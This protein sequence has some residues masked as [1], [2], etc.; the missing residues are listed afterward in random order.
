MGAS[1]VGMRGV[2]IGTDAA[3][4][5]GRRSRG[6]TSSARGGGIGPADG[7]RQIVEDGLTERTETNVQPPTSP[8]ASAAKPP[9]A[10]RSIVH[11]LR[12]RA[13][14]ADATR[15]SVI[16]C[17]SGNTH[18]RFARRIF[19]RA[20][21]GATYAPSDRF[22]PCKCASRCWPPL[23]IRGGFRR[24]PS[25]AQGCGSGRPSYRCG[26]RMVVVAVRTTTAARQG[27]EVTPTQFVGGGVAARRWRRS[28]APRTLLT[29]SPQ[30]F[31]RFDASPALMP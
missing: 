9:I 17:S 12:G 15:I 1:A 11:L 10:S 30:A 2:E 28:G 26:R 7:G 8:T 6:L 19:T 31:T 4:G 22:P 27:H 21:N 23:S 20:K 3:G 29:A 25:H 13:P 14:R 16:D 18:A 24:Q 5:F